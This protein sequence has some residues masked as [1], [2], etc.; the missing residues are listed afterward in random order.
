[1]RR[2]QPKKTAVDSDRTSSP[3]FYQRQKDSNVSKKPSIKPRSNSVIEAPRGMP[4][5]VSGHGMTLRK[6]RKQDSVHNPATHVSS[7]E[8][9]SRPSRASTSTLPAFSTIEPVVRASSHMPHGYTFVP[10]GNPYVTRNC[11][12]QTQRARQVV[13][14]VV[15]DGKKQIGIRVPQSVYAAV[16]QSEGATRLDRERNVRKHDEALKKRFSDASEYSV[17]QTPCPAHSF[18]D[19]STSLP[20]LSHLE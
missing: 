6:G 14:A 19:R 11:R 9:T 1:M 16:V 13:Y 3:S 5:A 20:L 7:S 10:K 15:D 2:R 4:A 8:I 12:Q 17:E 18:S